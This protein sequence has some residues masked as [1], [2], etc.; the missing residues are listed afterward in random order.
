MGTHIDLYQLTSLVP[1]HAAG[2]S[3]DE[4]VLHFFSRRLPTADGRPVRRALLFAGLQRCLDH[5]EHARFSSDALERLAAH[6][7][8]GPAFAQH[9]D[10]VARLA[11]WRFR[12]T[13]RAPREGTPLFDGPALR[14]DGAPLAVHDVHPAAY[15]PY[16]E[17]TT[18]LVSAKLIET[19]LL[20]ILN[21][22]VMV[23][24]KAFEVA[25][26]A[27][28][29]DPARAVLEFGTRRTH[30]EAAVD[31]AVAAY[32][33]GCTATSN[34]EA[35]VRH[36]VPLSGTMDHFA[37]QASEQPGQDRADTET[38]YFRAFHELYPGRDVL[39]V[40]TYDAFGDRT[41][42]RAAVAATDGEGPYGIRLDSQV[43]RDTVWR[44]RRLLDELGAPHTRIVVSGGL[45]EHA[46]RALGDAPI[47]GYGIG[48]R[49]VQS[50]D[51]PVGVGAVC[52]LAAIAGVPTMKL[53]RGSAKASLPGS[54]QV[55]RTDDGDRVGLANET[56]EGEPLLEVVWANGRRSAPSLTAVRDHAQA[57]MARWAPPF[58]ETR[59]VTVSDR[60]ADLVATVVTR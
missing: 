51:A 13:V 56:H 59:R 50:P 26:A 33:G 49:I 47:D 25:D 41:G 54:L 37:I 19:P 57:S 28:A 18:D 9:P 44:A 8:L 32:I 5:L 12:G 21:E 4:V 60:L 38:A 1:L 53:S 29:I 36:G 23:A 11:A 58:G 39:L 31:A 10:L 27:R 30:P 14:R 35:H 16:F 40:D 43:S 42:I 34:V 17:I 2:R 48:E 24:S 15:T 52:K 7:T 22:M 55:W 45:D 3:D 6:P 20:S 46:I